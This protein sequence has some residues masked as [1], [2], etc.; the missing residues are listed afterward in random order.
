MKLLFFL[1]SYRIFLF[2]TIPIIALLQNFK[3]RFFLAKSNLS[4]YKILDIVYSHY[5]H[6]NVSRETFLQDVVKLS[7]VYSNLNTKYCGH[8]LWISLYIKNVSRE[9]SRPW[10]LY[11]VFHKYFSFLNIVID[12]LIFYNK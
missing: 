4:L 12:C 10:C 5:P 7:E 3:K 9:T 1:F 6:W 11:L 2:T 8:S